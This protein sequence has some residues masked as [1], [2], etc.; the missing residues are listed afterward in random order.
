MAVT[1]YFEI[2]GNKYSPKVGKRKKNKSN[3]ENNEM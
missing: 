2:V 3:I 1:K